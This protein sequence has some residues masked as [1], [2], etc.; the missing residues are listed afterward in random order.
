MFVCLDPY[1]LFVCIQC[2][3]AC[4]FACAA[5]WGASP[6]FCCDVSSVSSS[7]SFPQDGRLH[8]GV[9]CQPA[10]TKTSSQPATCPC[11]LVPLH[12]HSLVCRKAR[13]PV[14]Q[15]LV[16][17][18]VHI[19]SYTLSSAS[20]V[21]HFNAD[22]HR[23]FLIIKL[24]SMWVYPDFSQHGCVLWWVNREFHNYNCLSAKKLMWFKVF[25]SAKVEYTYFLGLYYVL[26]IM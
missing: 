2:K 12:T 19:L 18:G 21:L 20:F 15:G 10:M 4:T 6:V 9:C 16:G 22:I 8:A 26:C 5:G 25:I 3:C 23:C 1:T 11:G 14:W 24:S 17:A 13:F 7:G